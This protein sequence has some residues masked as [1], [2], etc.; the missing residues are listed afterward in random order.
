MR[1]AIGGFQHETNTFAPHPA[2]LADFEAA[3]GWP[4]LTRGASLF[5]SVSGINLPIAGFIAAARAER[6]TLLPLTWCSA[7]PSAQVTREA[8]EHIA[9]LLLA[10]LQAAGPLDA[11]YLDLHGAMVA[12]HID[13]ADAELLRRVR[14]CVG[15]NVP[16]VASLDFHSNTSHSMVN[17][18]NALVAYRTYPH[19]DMADTG[20]RAL[21]CVEQLRTERWLARWRALPFLIPL[22]S[23]CTLVTPLAQLLPQLN[24]L[25]RGTIRALNFTAGFPCADVPECAPAI[26]G[27][28]LEE[29]ALV[30]A[31]DSLHAELVA[32]EHNFALQVHSIAATLARLQQLG[33]MPGAP[34]ILADTQDNPGAGGTCDTTSLIRALLAQH[35]PHVLA[36]IL[37]DPEAAARAHAVGVG[38]SV[39]LSLGAHTGTSDETPHEEPLQARFDVV[40][41]G[42][43][44]FTATGPFYRGARM[45]LGPMA[46]LRVQDLHIAVGSRRQQAADQAMFRHL[47]VEPRQFGVLALKS[48]VHFRADFAAMARQILLVTAPGANLADPAQLPFRKLPPGIRVAGGEAALTAAQRHPV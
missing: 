16:V 38:A 30:T 15:A 39:E 48:S 27:Y 45:Q 13:D 12:E 22:T 31:L 11:V 7:P 29:A 21:R 18:A 1:I 32:Q 17:V 33:S 3:D 14:Q 28:G 2:T 4:G 37:F 23:Q 35:V 47:G 20:E 10:D 36:G 40:A 8:Y 46:L 5:E 6:H 26:F 42:D 41:L 24:V 43:G 44:R 34:V 19:V 25:E 9:H